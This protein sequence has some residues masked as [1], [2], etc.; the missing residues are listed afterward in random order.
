LK[1]V[2]IFKNIPSSKTSVLQVIL[3][4][5]QLPEFGEKVSKFNKDLNTKLSDMEIVEEF[6]KLC[7]N[8]EE[9]E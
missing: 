4:L 7:I 8:P 1:L 6:E 9:T 3:N 5:S 2:E